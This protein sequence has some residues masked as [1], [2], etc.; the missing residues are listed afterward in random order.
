MIKEMDQVYMKI[1]EKKFFFDLKQKGCRFEV[2]KHRNL[3]GEVEISSPDL[4]IPENMS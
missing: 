3:R 1:I 4:N 2:Y